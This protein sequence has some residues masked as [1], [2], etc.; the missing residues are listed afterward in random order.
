MMD[1]QEWYFQ[2]DRKKE[3]GIPL[4]STHR[5]QVVRLKANMTQDLSIQFMY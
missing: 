4:T 1:G 3:A 5:R 2:V